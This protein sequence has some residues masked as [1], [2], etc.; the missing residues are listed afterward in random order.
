[1]EEPSPLLYSTL[2]PPVF[3]Q[4]ARTP[5]GAEQQQYQQEGSAGADIQKPFVCTFIKIQQ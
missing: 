1:M 3:Y 2:F 5:G 4:S